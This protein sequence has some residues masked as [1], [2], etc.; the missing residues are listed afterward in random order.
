MQPTQHTRSK[1]VAMVVRVLDEV[2]VF[3]PLAVGLL[4]CCR[5]DRT[6]EWRLRL[7]LYSIGRL[8]DL[9]THQINNARPPKP[10]KF[11]GMMAEASE[12]KRT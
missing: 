10:A 1:T 3:R 9:P 7:R 8:V 2:P 5:Y 6:T 12:A 11:A 4:V